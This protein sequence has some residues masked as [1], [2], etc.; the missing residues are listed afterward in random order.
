MTEPLRGVS[1][2]HLPKTGDRTDFLVES[3]SGRS[4]RLAFSGTSTAILGNLS[5][6]T[7]APL[8]QT[9]LP[10][11][12]ETALDS[13]PTYMLRSDAGRTIDEI[14]WRLKHEDLPSLLVPVAKAPGR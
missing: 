13:V 5:V 2:E 3:R 4:F 10:L 8:V 7:V 11:R 9:L 12:G 6:D 14:D 1:I